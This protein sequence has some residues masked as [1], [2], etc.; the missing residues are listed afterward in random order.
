MQVHLLAKTDD[1]LAVSKPDGMSCF[2]GRYDVTGYPRLVDI[3]GE[4]EPYARIVNRIDK[5]ASG[6]LI[7]AMN[8]EWGG[9]LSKM[10]QGVDDRRRKVYAALTDPPLWDDVVNS[11]KLKAQSGKMDIAVT[12]FKHLGEGKIEAELLS[13]GRTH[14]IRKHLAQLGAPIHGDALYKGPEADRLMLHC[15]DVWLDYD[16]GCWIHSTPPWVGE[17]DGALASWDVA[18]LTEMQMESIKN[19]PTFTG[20]MSRPDGMPW[21]EWRVLRTGGVEVPP[22]E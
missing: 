14:Q 17:E 19:A 16:G 2:D 9:I 1:W 3:V 8:K 6:I 5:D 22:A 20:P 21:E 18:P 7:F 4:H 10:W 11:T 13:H 12:A 15:C